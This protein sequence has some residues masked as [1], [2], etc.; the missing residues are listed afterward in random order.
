[1]R[2]VSVAAV[3]LFALVLAAYY[4]AVHTV[5]GQDALL[6][7]AA[8]NIARPTD[9]ELS[10]LRVHVCGSAAPLPAPGRANA[11]IAVLTP[12]HFF[13]VDAGSGSANNLGVAQLPLQRL[14]AVLLTHFHSD[15]ITDLPNININ[16]WATGHQGP[17]QVYGPEGVSA[18][19]DGFNAALAWDRSYRSAHHG[20]Q[21]LPPA[22]GIMEA[23]EQGTEAVMTFGDLTITVFPAAHEPVA[24]AVS[25]RF[26]YRGRSVVITGDTLVTERLRTMV[27]DADLL[28]TDALSLPIIKAMHNGAAAGGQDRIARILA[29]IQDYHASTAD[30]AELTRSTGVGMTALYHL[31]PGPR[32]AVMENIFKREFSDNMVLTHDG[33]EFELLPDSD[34][35]TVRD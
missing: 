24:P 22:W 23:V 10:G 7:R 32:N 28:L 25:Y 11:C 1:M 12:E 9:P 34:T 30:V 33:M 26:D 2:R 21:L 16:A 5:Q 13:I 19:V 6:K 4:G 18:V 29:D 27:D 3:V 31:V 15:H 8:G 17:L 35:I 14:N 20:E